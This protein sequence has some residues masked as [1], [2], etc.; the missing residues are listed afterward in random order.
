MK[1][2]KTGA[3]KREKKMGKKKKKS[4]GAGAAFS[5]ILDNRYSCK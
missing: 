2:A 1:T 5:N 4:W 3:R